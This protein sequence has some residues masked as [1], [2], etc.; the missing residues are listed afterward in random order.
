MIDK[1]RNETNVVRWESGLNLPKFDE[2]YIDWINRGCPNRDKI[3][4]IRDSLPV[5]LSLYEGLLPYFNSLK[6]EPLVKRKNEAKKDE[7]SIVVTSDWHI[8]FQDKEA[9]KLFLNFLYEYQPDE[10]ILNG[11][12]NDMTSFSTHPKLRELANAFSTGKPERE[13]WLAIAHLLRQILPN[14]K[15]TYVG[16]QCH[17]GWLDKWSQLSPILVEDYNYTLPGWLKLD[18]FGIY[19]EPEVVDVLGN[20]E[21]LIT[22]GTVARS[23]GGNSAYATMEQ[24][25]TSIIQGHTHRLA[26]VFKTTSIG[27]TVAVECGCLCD[28]Q[29]WYHLK[30]R[31]LMMDWQQGFVLVNTKGNSFSTQCVPIIRDSND[32]PYF[33]IGKELYK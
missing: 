1:E 27:E 29:P 13:E 23:K 7:R 16:S 2:L 25:G 8:P 5:S 30:G 10:L 17:E 11:N 12:I 19:Y 22:H 18:E 24:E 26:Q 33:W 20:K 21:L 15:I 3:R 32:K 4:E 6:D 14:G 28:R 9:L 31:R